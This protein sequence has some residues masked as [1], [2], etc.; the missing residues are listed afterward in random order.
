[1]GRMNMWE[2]VYFDNYWSHKIK[3]DENLEV[4]DYLLEIF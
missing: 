2:E 3:F 4:T 1:M